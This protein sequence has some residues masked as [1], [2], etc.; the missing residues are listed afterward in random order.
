M[1]TDLIGFRVIIFDKRDW[2][3]EYRLMEWADQISDCP[4]CLGGMYIA[5]KISSGFKLEIV[6]QIYVRYSLMT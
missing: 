5:E 4:S 1:I 3:R 2:V 6:K